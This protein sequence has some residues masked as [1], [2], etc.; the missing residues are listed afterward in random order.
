MTTSTNQQF[1]TVEDFRRGRH[2]L[3]PQHLEELKKELLANVRAPWKKQ[4]IL[5]LSADRIRLLPPHWCFIR[6]T[7]RTDGATIGGNGYVIGQDY[8]SEIK[9]VITA[10][11]GEK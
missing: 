10:F 9:E 5:N 6:F 1:Y 3:Y 2:P 8:N 7:F 4:R 11:I